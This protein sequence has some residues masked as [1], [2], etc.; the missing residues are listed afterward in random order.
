[1]YVAVARVVFDFYGNAEI[2]QKRRVLKDLIL[3]LHKDFNVSV[4]QVD[5][6]EDVERG[7]LGVTA[8]AAS[9]TGARSVVKRALDHLDSVSPARVVHEDT[10]IFGYE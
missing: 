9:E 8:V 6:F 5:D 7:V 3:E 4:T 10:D 2:R 1:M